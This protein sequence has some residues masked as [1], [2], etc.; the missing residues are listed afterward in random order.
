MSGISVCE[1]D[2]DLAVDPASFLLPNYFLPHL[3]SYLDRLGK[4]NPEQDKTLGLTIPPALVAAA[5]AVIE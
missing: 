1:T 5:N 3:F 4:I 2:H